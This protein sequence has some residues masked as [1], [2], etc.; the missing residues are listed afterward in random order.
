MVHVRF[1]SIKPATIIPPWAMTRSHRTA[2][3][4]ITPLS[5]T[6][7]SSTMVSMELTIQQLVLE[8]SPV[9]S[10][11]ASTLPSVFK[12]Y[13]TALPVTTLQSANRRSPTNTSGTTNTA[14]GIVALFKNTSGN[15]NTA[16]GAE[17]LFSNTT[18]FN[19]T[20]GGL[21]ALENNTAGHDNTG[22]GFQA[23]K[24][25]TTGNNNIAVGSNAGGNL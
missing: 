3:A 11:A 8:R 1:C 10:A 17:A 13:L 22:Q 4:A 2:M 5:A 16:Y 25:N 23:L 7:H 15:Q 12:R 14:T 19:N 6:L 20:A 9:T 21:L 18:G 24:A